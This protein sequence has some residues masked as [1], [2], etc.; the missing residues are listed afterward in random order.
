MAFSFVGSAVIAQLYVP[1]SA[2]GDEHQGNSVIRKEAG[3]TLDTDGNQRPDIK[4]YFENTPIGIWLREKSTVSFTLAVMHN[5]SL[6]QD[7]VFRVDMKLSKTRQRDPIPM[8]AAPGIANFYKGAIE[9]E[10]VKAYYRWVYESVEDSVDVHLFGGLGGPRI[11]WVVRPG[12]DPSDISLTFTGQDSLGID[13][14]GDLQIYLEDKWIELKEAVA[15][16]VDANDNI[17]PLNWT[18]S[19]TTDSA[20]H[21]GFEFEDYDPELPL[22]L[23]IG[24]PPLQ[25]GG[26]L[27]P[28]NLGWCSYVGG[29]SG[30]ELTSVEVDEVGNPYTCGHSWSAD[31]P[32]A[33]GT[34]EFDPFQGQAYGWNNAVIMKFKADNKQLLWATYY[35]GSTRTVSIPKTGAQKLAVANEVGNE[36]E[37]VFV[38]GSTNT[39][40]FSSHAEPVTEFE[41]ADVS[42]YDG[43]QRRM[44][45]GAFRKL[46]GVRDWATTHGEIGDATWS[47]DGLAID[48]DDQGTL[49]VGGKLG[50]G[51]A[52]PDFQSLTPSGAFNRAVGGG[53]FIVFDLDY[54]IEWATTF[55]ELVQY[56]QVTDLRIVK[57]TLGTPRKQLWLT[58]ST[59]NGYEVPLDLVPPPTGG[60]YQTTGGSV[61]AMLAC[62]D[63]TNRLIEYCTMWGDPGP[64]GLSI[65]VAYGLDISEKGL[66][67]VVGYTD[68]QNLTS[69][70][71]PDPGGTGVHHTAT[72]QGNNTSP[73]QWSDGFILMMKPNTMELVY[74]TLI[75]GVKDD[76]LL[77]VGHDDRQVYLTGETRSATGFSTDL[78]AQWYYQPQ[79]GTE[80]K[81]DAILLSLWDDQD[82]PTVLWRSAFAGTQSD[83]G[84]G[85]A[86]SETEV[87]LVGATASNA[88][89]GPFPLLEFDAGD[90]DDFFQ[91]WNMG[92]DGIG[93]VN[94]YDFGFAMDFEHDGFGEAPV[95]FHFPPHDGFIASFSTISPVGTTE[96]L[97]DAADP[98]VVVPLVQGTQWSVRFPDRGEWQLSIVD[99]IGRTIGTHNSNGAPLLV[100]LGS[101]ASGMYVLRA[102]EPGGMV[103]FAK[104]IRP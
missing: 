104:I 94:W 59:G 58:G 73:S 52:Y 28:R 45:V 31:F 67:W 14:E 36:L 86:A 38:T 54:Q 84:W 63:I 65:S 43:G 21:A 101:Q 34:E 70:E 47:E 32:V 10:D 37:H 96:W 100:D 103:C 82:S 33:P 48:V 92:G 91:D 55:A 29:T 40:D 23:Q 79:F 46:N 30:D 49:V 22:I 97:T 87:F 85:I 81:R 60:Y 15:Y 74:G 42:N 83:R 35:G 93:F 76:I 19:Y 88:W 90:A 11:A 56:T 4:A 98:L 12:G 72:H 25:L 17:I 51:S 8:F 61:M 5:D 53:F 95:E 99:A 77:D 16:Q 39:E 102:S 71:C 6:T 1:P 26:P 80:N 57:S 20:V 7:T 50:Y 41:D 64:N 66:V 27:E 89:D 13:W 78:N 3:Q 24:Y 68:S 9:A 2:F 18:A 44:W 75:G 69:T 62:I